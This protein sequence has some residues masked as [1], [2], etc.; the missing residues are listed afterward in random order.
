MP[1]RALVTVYSTGVVAAQADVPMGRLLGRHL[2]GAVAA[3]G[4][5]PTKPLAVAW[6]RVTHWQ[7]WHDAYADPGSSLSRRLRIVQGFV[8]DWLDA[9]APR[10]VR[11]VSV[12]A[13]DGRDLLEVL[14]SGPTPSR[15]TA[16]L[17][18]LDAGLADRARTL[19][20]GLPG[21][22]V[23]TA[24]AGDPGRV[25]RAAAGRPRPPLRRAG[26]RL[27]R[28]RRAR[29][30][31]AARPLRGRRTRHLD[32]HPSG[33]R[34]HAV[35]ASVAGRERGS[36]RW[37]SRRCP[38]AA[39]RWAWPTSAERTT[40]RRARLPPVHLPRH[41]WRRDQRRDAGR[42][43]AAGRPL[44]R[45]LSRYRGALASRVPR[46]ARR[47]GCRPGRGC[48]SWAAAPAATRHTCSSG[49]SRC[50]PPTPWRRSSA[51][52]RERGLDP[53]EIDVL[54]DD[55]GGP[56]AAVVASAVLLHL[57]P[58]E[59][60]GVLDRLLA[61]VEPGGLLAATLKEGDG[62]GWS[63]HKLGLPRY[64]TYW[65][66]DPLRALLEQ[67]GWRR[68]VAGAPPGRP[69]RVAARRRP[70]GR[71]SGIGSRGSIPH[72]SAR[73]ELSPDISD[74]G[75]RLLSTC[76]VVGGPGAARSPGL[77][78]EGEL[79]PV[80]PAGPS[81]RPAHRAGAAG[82][83]VCAAARA[84]L[85]ASRRTRSSRPSRRSRPHRPTRATSR[86]RR[87]RTDGSRSS[88]PARRRAPAG[89]P[90]LRPRAAVDPRTA[91]PR[92]VRLVLR[93]EGGAARSTT[94][95]APS[96]TAGWPWPA[97]CSAS[98]PPRSWPCSP[99]SSSSAS[100]SSWRAAPAE[101]A[102]ADDRYSCV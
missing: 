51:Q 62:F 47:T 13:G 64:F 12:C 6:G 27:R 35:G 56:W 66:A 70:A 49:A 88:P 92:P 72:F 60:A 99:C 20:A 73:G 91:H 37:P 97:W 59:L 89:G 36:G 33:A 82:P 38:T 55:L 95:R 2:G 76:G 31:G 26:Q 10:A 25:C 14:G 21:V 63:D 53:V 24:D 79:G 75:P 100:C 43:R 40:R 90:R 19:G 65:R 30:V 54:T 77:G 96:A 81:H 39:P 69:G 86:M 94:T 29:A 3:H 50:S 85:P 42:L 102:D 9:T 28:R 87:R 68:R 52:Q 101:A 67:H 45:G 61:A 84:G 46:R 16:T 44:P 93:A 74:I 98:S 57:T 22:E 80:V 17:V 58:G 18:E 34:P 4:P 11:V 7:T 5:Q 8:R 23:R 71:R 1:P 78:S 41:G 48:W 15:V 32:A 83:A